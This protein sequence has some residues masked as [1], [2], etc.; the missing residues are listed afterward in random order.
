LSTV[1][2]EEANVG[3][4]YERCFSL[5]DGNAHHAHKLYRNRTHT[6]IARDTLLQMK[7]QIAQMPDDDDTSLN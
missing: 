2:D 6:Q 4:W 3:P 5:A 7:R 1:L